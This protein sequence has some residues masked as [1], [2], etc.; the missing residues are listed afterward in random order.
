MRARFG[1]LHPSLKRA[2]GL[3]VILALSALSFWK[4]PYGLD[5]P[6]AIGPFLNGIFPASAPDAGMPEPDQPP[7]LL[8]E[9]GAFKDLA[10][11]E[12]SDGLIPYALNEPCWS[13]GAL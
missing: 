1:C 8:S 2:A 13:D 9:T 3:L 7:S 11:L 6:E 12:P 5:A 4:P 10:S